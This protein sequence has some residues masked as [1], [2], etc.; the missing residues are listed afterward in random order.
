MKMSGFII[1][2]GKEHSVLDV[3]GHISLDFQ[4]RLSI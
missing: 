3:Q 4:C 1:P 2:S